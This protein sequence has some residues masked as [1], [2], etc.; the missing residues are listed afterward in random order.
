MNGLLWAAISNARRDRLS[1]GF[2]VRQVVW[3][4]SHLDF[5]VA[6]SQGINQPQWAANAIADGLSVRAAVQCQLPADELSSIESSS[7]QVG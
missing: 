7:S 4:H 2:G 1:E 3:M 6:M 5:D